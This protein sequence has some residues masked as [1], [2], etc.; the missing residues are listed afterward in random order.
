MPSDVNTYD[1]AP[2]LQSHAMEKLLLH[3]LSETALIVGLATA[4]KKL[5]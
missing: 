4:M 5:F 2:G 1:T 3:S